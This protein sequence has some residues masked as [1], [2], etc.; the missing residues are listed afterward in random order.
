MERHSVDAVVG[1]LN[2]AKV[3]YLIVGGLAVVAHGYVRFTSV[4]DLVLDPDPEAIQRAIVALEGQGYRP[5]APVPFAEFADP[6]ARA[7]WVRDK[8]LRVFSAA[9]PQHPAT[10]LDLFVQMPFDF[11]DAYRR[12][13]LKEIAPGLTASFVGLADLIDMKRAVGRPQDLQDVEQLERL[14]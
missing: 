1:A 2:G 10:E 4:I 8:G 6:E 9:S 11:E 3:R 14:R 7:R 5:R 12:A 13:E